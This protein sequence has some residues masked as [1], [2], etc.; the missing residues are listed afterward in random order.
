M[1]N[2][3]YYFFFFSQMFHLPFFLFYGFFKCF[4]RLISFILYFYSLLY[5][6]LFISP[7]CEFFSLFLNY[8]LV[9]SCLPPTNPFTYLL[10]SL[11]SS[12]SLSSLFSW[13]FLLFPPPLSFFEYFSLTNFL[14]LFL[15]SSHQSLHLSLL[16]LISLSALFFCFFSSP[17]SVS[18]LFSHYSLLSL[19]IYPHFCL[20]SFVSSPPPS[21][22]LS[23][24]LFI[25]RSLN[26]S[27]F[28]KSS[29][30]RLTFFSLTFT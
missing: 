24:Y 2:C 5:T 1:T 26:I 6:S 30:F 16:S 21:S 27:L 9:C 13:L 22:N 20:I 23:S 12:I 7:F 14:S 3:Y 11:L 25:S 8:F 28:Q 17:S 29:T 4:T 10:L 18:L 15:S 19:I